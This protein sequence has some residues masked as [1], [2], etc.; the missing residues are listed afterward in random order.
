MT[1]TSRPRPSIEEEVISAAIKVQGDLPQRI[2]R[3]REQVLQAPRE[4][5]LVR[6]RELTN[7]VKNNPDMPRPIQLAETVKETLRKLPISIAEDERLVGAHSEKF[8][9]AILTPE[10]KSNFLIAE[11]DNFDVRETIR[12]EI[13]SEE[14]RELREEILPHWRD[15]SAFDDMMAHQS[16]EALFYERIIAIVF[17][18]DIVNDP[19]LA[20]INY[21]KA[22]EVGIEEIIDEAKAGMV[23]VSADDP[24]AERKRTFYQSVIISLDAIIE[25]ANRYSELALAS[26][27]TASSKERERELREIAEIAA[28][29][30]AKPAR[31]FREALQ[32]VFF[33][34]LGILQLDNS[35]EV[36]LGRIDQYLY[37]YYKKDLEEGKISRDEALELIEEFYIKFNRIMILVEY[38]ITKV[39]DGNT[40]RYKLTLGGVG[41]DG[42]DATNDL[43]YIFLEAANAMRLIS[44]N[45]AVR[46]HTGVPESFIKVAVT[47]MTNGS[48][49]MH[50]F[51][52]EVFVNG[53]TR[54]GLPVEAAREYIITGCTIPVGGSVYGP[55]CSAFLNMP[56]ALELFLNGGKPIMTVN[57][58]G[59]EDDL[60]PPQCDTW[61]EF[62]D[63]LKEFLIS[64]VDCINDSVNV[65]QQTCDRLLPNP[66]L[67]ALVDGTLETAKDV[68][69]GGA[70]YNMTGLALIGPATFF[71]SIATIRDIVYEK[72]SHTL[73]EV[74]EWVKSDFMD[75]ESEQQMILSRAPKYG[76]D[77]PRV[78]DIAKDMVDFLEET[79]KGRTTYRNGT[80][81]LGMHSEAHH[82][83]QG[84]AVAA[85]PDGREEGQM[86]SPGAG[87][88]S[89]MDR[90][91]PTAS[92]RSMA[93][94]DYTKVYGGPSCNMRFSPKLFESED[95]LSK[96]TDMLKGYFFKLGGPH[97]QL[98][99][100]DAKTL[101][102]AQQ[103]PEKYED[104]L[105]RV[106]G[107]SARFI[108]LT[109][110]TQEEIIRR[111]EMCDCN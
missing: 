59:D 7:I 4:I 97:L 75:Y 84:A 33:T 58:T 106:T 83:Y 80:W 111:S 43:S 41:R 71:D 8:K 69:S 64:M 108:D 63:Q 5:S 11:L 77:D 13:S 90:N 109:L 17:Q 57:E 42:T 102:E 38:A 45:L 34:F 40:S 104:L 10:T 50:V 51:N 68:K 28:H 49:T 6:A 3:M 82:V 29:V 103:N 107:Y 73:N 30:P 53:G 79:L 25:F 92:L 95:G 37:P 72:K 19:H 23:N 93:K 32:S 14:K 74:V 39:H 61:D 54:A 110:P 35:G 1:T 16:E 21:R 65:V 26:A 55:T 20:D 12:F 27:D 66:I 31:T 91:G 96:F 52:D 87:P 100:A 76:N 88:T 9:S 56:K 86:V 48:N 78:D 67:S 85:T 94:I 47:M 2:A 62:Y 101:R 36:P 44:P 22:L 24:D 105:V 18:H 60:P 98:T 70:R 15:N 89:G 99:V 46:L 81:I